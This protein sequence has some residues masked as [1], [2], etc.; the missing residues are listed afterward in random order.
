MHTG[1]EVGIDDVIKTCRKHQLSLMDHRYYWLQKM[2]LNFLKVHGQNIIIAYMHDSNHSS[3]IYTGFLPEALNNELQ[4]LEI[5]ELPLSVP[6]ESF[7]GVLCMQD[8]IPM[9]ID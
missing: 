9:L 7:L 1:H 6:K 4:K 5:V 2:P 8:A 3:V